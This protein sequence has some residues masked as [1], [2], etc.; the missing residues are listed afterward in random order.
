MRLRQI[1]TRP[2]VLI[3]RGKQQRRYACGAPCNTVSLNACTASVGGQ[4]RTNNNGLSFDCALK[5]GNNI[6]T[7]RAVGVAIQRRLSWYPTLSGGQGA[8]WGAPSEQL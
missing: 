7:R 8:G 3:L 5:F 1:N 6:D 2:D 4:L